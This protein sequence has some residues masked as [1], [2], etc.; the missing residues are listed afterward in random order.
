MA[1]KKQKRAAGLAKREAFLAEVKADGLKALEADRVRQKE[2]REIMEDAAREI[3]AHHQSILGKAAKSKK[4]TSFYS[5]I[6]GR[7]VN[8]ATIA[9]ERRTRG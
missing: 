8:A 2:R 7:P 4:Q 6:Q 1:T 9:A 3:N 5:E